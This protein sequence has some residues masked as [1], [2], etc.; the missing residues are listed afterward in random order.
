MRY[1][2]TGSIGTGKTTVA[3]VF[4]ELGFVIYDADE[5]VH[6]L[7]KDKAVL[8]KVETM[9]PMAFENGQM[10][11]K[12]V[13]DVIFHD[14]KKKKELENFIHPLVKE[15]ILQLDNCIIEVPLLFE[16]KMEKLFDKVIVVYCDKDKQIK[17]VMKRNKISK[18]EATSRVDS[19]MDINEKIKL[20]DFVVDNSGKLCNIKKQVNDIVSKL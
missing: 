5:M 1:A 14:E 6:E 19:Q 18:E 13:A 16:S 8:D 7:Y 4:K 12:V 17:R 10:H 2:I 20:G 11:N 3:N 15:K 9:F